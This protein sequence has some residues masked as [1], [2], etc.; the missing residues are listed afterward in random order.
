[1]IYITVYRNGGDTC[2]TLSCKDDRWI[3][4]NGG[5]KKRTGF[6]N[7]YKTMGEITY[8]VHDALHDG[9]LFEIK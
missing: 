9:C 7:L 4:V 3:K 1:M 8:W 2:L 5:E 6:M